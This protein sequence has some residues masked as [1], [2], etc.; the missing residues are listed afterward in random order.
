[1]MGLMLTWRNNPVWKPMYVTPRDLMM[2]LIYVELN[3]RILG[4]KSAESSDDTS[5]VKWSTAWKQTERVVFVEIK[6]YKRDVTFV[7]HWWCLP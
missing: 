7:N 5:I 3:S 4:K 2:K 1:M 6:A